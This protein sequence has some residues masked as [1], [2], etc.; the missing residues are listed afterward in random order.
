MKSELGKV[1]C[2]NIIS[3]E[4]VNIERVQCKE[5]VKLEKFSTIYVT[6]L[7]T[8]T[9]TWLRPVEEHLSM[10]ACPEHSALNL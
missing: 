8:T 2:F 5:E 3:V 9:N 10:S 4:E 1:C 6:Y 7:L